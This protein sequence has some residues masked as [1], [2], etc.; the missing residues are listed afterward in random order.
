MNGQPSKDHHKQTLDNMYELIFF[1]FAK[2]KKFCIKFANYFSFRIGNNQSN[3]VVGINNSGL[4][5]EDCL[6]SNSTMVTP[7][8]AFQGKT[9]ETPVAANY[10]A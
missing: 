8:I 2:K 4:A 10:L 7:L 1:F 5:N 9:K 6:N 3:G